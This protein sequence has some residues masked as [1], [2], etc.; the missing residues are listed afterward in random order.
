MLS[1]EARGPLP[2]PVPAAG[3]TSSTSWAT[4]SGLGG[5]IQGV[6]SARPS[7]QG[8]LKHRKD[9]DDETRAL[10]GEVLDPGF[11]A[12]RGTARTL[13]DLAIIDFLDE[14]SQNDDWVFR[15]ALVDFD[16]R[17]ASPYYLM[18]EAESLDIAGDL[19]ARSRPTRSSCATRRPPCGAR[20]S[21]P[22]PRPRASVPAGLRPDPQLRPLRHAAGHVGAGRRS[23]PTCCRASPSCPRTPRTLEKLFGQGG[24]V[25]KASRACGRR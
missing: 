3:S 8:Y 10:L 18:S 13:R 16:G 2:R 1:Q 24:I 6:N 11:L 23:S 9:L 19:R 5:L 17:R 21:R 7:E 14:I 12:A 22:W 15:N 4:T 25:T 20:R